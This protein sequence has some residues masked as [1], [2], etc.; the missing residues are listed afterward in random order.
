MKIRSLFLGSIAAL[1]VSAGAFAANLPGEPPVVTALTSLD[2]CDAF[3]ISGLTISSDSH[4]LQITGEV[5]YNFE[6]GDYNNSVWVGTSPAGFITGEDQTV[7]APGYRTEFELVELPDGTFEFVLVEYPDDFLD[8]DSRLRAHVQFEAT[9]DTSFGPAIANI[10][11]AVDDRHTFINTEQT[12][13]GDDDVY[14]DH[15]FISVGDTTRIIAGIVQDGLSDTIDP[16]V[17]FNH[18]G[19][20]NNEGEDENFIIDGNGDDALGGHAIQI[21]SSFG[22]G[23]T[24]GVGIENLQGET[25]AAELGSLVGVLTYAGPGVA[26]YFNAAAVGILDGTVDVWAARAGVTWEA[27]V[28]KVGLGATYTYQDEFNS[29]FGGVATAE[30]GFDLFTLALSGEYAAA[31]IGGVSNTGYGVGGSIGV[32]VTEGVAINLGARYFRDDWDD[33]FITNSWQAEAELVADITETLEASARVGI[34][35]GDLVEFNTADDTIFYA[36]AGLTWTPGS[37]T[38]ISL[39]GEANSLEAWKVLFEAR[40]SFD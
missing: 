22:D 25:G 14:I 15:A 37:G 4:C 10:R 9:S 32:A 24:A 40:K 1:G 20:Y 7:D 34:H 16:V 23:I 38:S 27:D 8:T 13:F 17:P 29:Y 3:G 11:L 2:V 39:D 6:F 21:I 36:G 30:V 12:R 28:V 26:A 35:G 18:L 5:R 19:L 31:E 33:G